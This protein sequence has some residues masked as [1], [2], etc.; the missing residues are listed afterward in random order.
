MIY[1]E[2]HLGTIGLSK[3]YLTEL[4]T[5]TAT[6]CFGVAGISD[7]NNRQT[8]LRLL[9]GGGPERSLKLKYNKQFL[10]IDLHIL[11]V[12]GVN[13][14]ETVRSIKHK[15]RYTLEELTELEVGRINIFVDGIKE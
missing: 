11:M 12:Y 14:T 2:N 4:I 3:Q 15:I 7:R 9:S 13:M 8:F 5:H 10:E 6:N 1:L